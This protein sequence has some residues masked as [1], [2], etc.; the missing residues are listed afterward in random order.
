MKSSINGG[1]LSFAQTTEKMKILQT[2]TLNIE[3]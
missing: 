1:K 3:H 2:G